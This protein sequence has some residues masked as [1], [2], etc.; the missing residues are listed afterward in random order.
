[1]LCYQTFNIKLT[2]NSQCLARLNLSNVVTKVFYDIFCGS[3]PVRTTITYCSFIYRLEVVIKA[4]S[5]FL[6]KKL[7]K[8]LSV[9][10][11]M[12]LLTLVDLILACCYNFVSL[13]LEHCFII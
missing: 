9:P 1:M 12:F 13:C 3:L 11:L 8:K 4:N 7:D 10:K 5:G 6:V 2:L